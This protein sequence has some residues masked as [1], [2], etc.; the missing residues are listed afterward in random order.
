MECLFTHEIGAHSRELAFVEV[1]ITQKKR[2]ADNAVKHR[3]TE[4]LQT[5]IVL[6]RKAAVRNRTAQKLLILKDVAD[7]LLERFKRKHL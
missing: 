4:K 6:L 5:F 2:I 1:F 3:V 7:A